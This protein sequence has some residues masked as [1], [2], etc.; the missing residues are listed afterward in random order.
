MHEVSARRYSGTVA[1]TRARDAPAVSGGRPSTFRRWGLHATYNLR[2]TPLR[3]LR[4]IRRKN[5]APSVEP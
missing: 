4:P 3:D 1:P 5:G 2:G